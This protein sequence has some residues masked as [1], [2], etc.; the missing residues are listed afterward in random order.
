MPELPEVETV[1]R[2]LAPVLAG[3]TIIKA[4]QNR[5]D[6]RFPFPADFVKRLHGQKVGMLSRR[7]KYLL[8]PL[9]S[10]ETL[11]MHLGM[12]GRVT[13]TKPDD[14]NPADLPDPAHDHVILILDNGAIIRYNDPRRFGFMTLVKDDELTTHKLFAGL[15]PEPLGNHFHAQYLAQAAQNRKAPLKSFLLDQKIVAGLG[16]I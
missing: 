7:A 6:L 8:I 4:V 15:G 10:N 12:S 14:K 13:I 1:K 3:A 9:K 5:P 2:G 16:N 11:V